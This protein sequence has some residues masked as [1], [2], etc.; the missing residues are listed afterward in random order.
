MSAAVWIVI[1][2]VILIV[3]AGG[4]GNGKKQ[5]SGKPFRTDHPHYM[6]DDESECSVCGARFPDK[7]MVCPK[8]GARFGAAREDDTEFIEEMELWDDDDE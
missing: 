4:K 6:S 2:L 7:V 8:C 5:S 1:G 3:L